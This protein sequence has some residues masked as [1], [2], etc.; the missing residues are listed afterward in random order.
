[1][2]P[3]Y[4]GD[5]PDGSTGALLNAAATEAHSWL[6]YKAATDTTPWWPGS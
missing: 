2:P 5:V 1:M 4:K 6:M 3:D